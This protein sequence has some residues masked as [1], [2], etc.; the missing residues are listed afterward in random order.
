MTFR[1]DR[2]W[3][4]NKD[5]SRKVYDAFRSAG[6]NFIDTADEVHERR[7]RQRSER[8]RQPPQEHVPVH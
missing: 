5:E 6:G 8:G 4:A 2:G 1:E 7:P 3:G